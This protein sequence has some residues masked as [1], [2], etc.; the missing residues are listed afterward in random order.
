MKELEE[1]KNEEV[2]VMCRSGNRSS[3]AVSYLESQG[4]ENASNLKGGMKAWASEI[5]PSVPV[6]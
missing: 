5:D 4:F 2:I 1:K 3:R 6:A